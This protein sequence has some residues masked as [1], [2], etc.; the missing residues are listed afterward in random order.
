MRFVIRFA[1]VSIAIA[2]VLSVGPSVA[3]QEKP[4]KKD[5]ATLNKLNSSLQFLVRKVRPA[6]V[7]VLTTGYAP[8]QG[9]TPGLVATQRG[10]G[11]GVI[12]DPDGFIVTNAHVVEGAQRVQIL[13]AASVEGSDQTEFILNPRGR[14]VSARIVG[15]DTES[16]L[17]VLKIEQK[18][19]PFLQLA[20]SYKVYQ[21]Q[22]VLAFGNP[23]GLE[24]SVTMGV[25]SSVARQIRPEDSVIYL[26]TDAPI[27]PGNSGG[28]LVNTEGKVVGI[29]TFILSQSGGSEGLGFAI[30]S[31][32]VRNVYQQLKSDGHVHRGQIGVQAQTITPTMA[33]GLHLSRDWG[34]ILG[35]VTP[36]G[37]A[38]EAGL[39][40]G[41]L[42]MT[43]DGKTVENSRRFDVTI[44]QHALGDAVTLEVQRGSEK[45]TKVVKIAERLND[46]FRF[47]DMVSENNLISKLGIFALELN[48][49]TV[50][51][52]PPLFISNHNDHSS[53]P[54]KGSVFVKSV[55]EA[56][57]LSVQC[58]IFC[59]IPGSSSAD[60]RGE[61]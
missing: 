4:S 35:D 22:L 26:Q 48:E 6:V 40:V 5:L 24:N 7:Q 55:L 31:N 36:D 45:L 33:A 14:T 10:T 37:P 21:G 46:P 49:K 51:M 17:A 61:L 53:Q 41:D 28:A 9:D 27:N 8:V 42:I 38:D 58:Q 39:K 56:G 13:L 29:N 47:L 30:P 18:G 54:F 3:G 34:V 11:T 20:D 15:V 1:L 44:Y 19:M 2:F 57:S 60:I 25:V 16:D 23:L 12:L 50:D 52:L 59:Q 32:I 43:I